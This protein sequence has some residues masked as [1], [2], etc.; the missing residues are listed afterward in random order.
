[1]SYIHEKELL[2]WKKIVP[3]CE[4]V[5]DVGCSN[6]NIFYE[7]NPT[8]KEIHLFDAT[9]NEKIQKSLKNKIANKKNIIFNNFALGSKK[10]KLPF[11][12]EYGSF[13]Y[14]PEEPKF[15]GR[16]S[17]REVEIQTLEEYISNRGILKIDFLKIDAE[18]Y[19]FEII[20]GLGKYLDIVKYIQFEDFEKFYAGETTEQVLFYFSN[21]N[22]YNVGGSP[23]NYL[24]T[25]EELSYLTKV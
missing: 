13:M 8:L 12:W 20:K 5:F 19:D 6:D 11:Y 24:V 21:R 3:T 1:M 9:P 18:G 17:T 25:K 14:R 16:F 4:I 22:I 2:L 7:I 23:R 10:G 15:A